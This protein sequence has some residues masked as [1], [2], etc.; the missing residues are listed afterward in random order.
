MQN[1]T[2]H[3]SQRINFPDGTPLDAG[4]YPVRGLNGIEAIY[5]IQNGKIQAVDHGTH[6]K[7][8]DSVIMVESPD[9]YLVMR[10]EYSG[11]IRLDDR[12]EFAFVFMN[13]VL[14]E[15]K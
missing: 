15:I 14:I 13:N 7:D 5:E 10:G 9:H 6:G 8:D 4:W 12:P 2:L 1:D 11:E 3:I